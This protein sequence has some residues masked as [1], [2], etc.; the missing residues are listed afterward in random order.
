MKRKLLILSSIIAAVVVAAGFVLI[1]VARER[2]RR[3]RCM[4]PLECCF[5]KAMLM[6]AMD[7]QGAFPPNFAALA[8]SYAANAIL[9][10]CPSSGTQP[11]ALA[12]VDEWMDYIY[13]HWPDGENT[14]T[15]YPW[16]YER[17]L[18]H[19]G[20]GIQIAPIQ[21]PAFWDEGAQWLQKFARE[22]PELIIPMPE[23]L[24]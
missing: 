20:G 17:R 7:H 24:P 1:P 11:G 14:P 18:S 3:S 22:H 19:H 15:N 10:I 4:A 12:N 5:R 2:A 6:Y 21:G 16:V 23:D 8:D 13:I 9:Y